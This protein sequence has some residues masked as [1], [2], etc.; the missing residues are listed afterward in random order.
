MRYT[1]QYIPINKIKHVNHVKITHRIKELRK[2][3][4]DCMQLLIV[5]KNGKKGGYMIVN[6]NS[7]FE[8]I[9]NHTRK[10]LVPCLVDES[11]A[12]SSIAS[13]VH[14]FR[15]RK[16]PFDIPQVKS[17][18][19]TIASWSIINSFLRKEPRFKRLSLNQQIK[20]IW[21]AIHYKRATILSM[22]A[23]VDDLLRK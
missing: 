18:K 10:K 7:S 12:S 1:V 5:R 6:G 14:R 11:R 22:R 2:V 8:S 17:D 4:Q 9:K 16:L 13:I 15:K 21:I 3:A 23:R 20:V 19:L